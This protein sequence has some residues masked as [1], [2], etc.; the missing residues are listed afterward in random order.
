MQNHLR[1]TYCE[2]ST[3]VCIIDGADNNLLEKGIGHVIPLNAEC[4]R[5][6]EPQASESNI[7]RGPTV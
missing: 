6:I 2:Q 1:P 3:V 7:L 5:C 4:Q